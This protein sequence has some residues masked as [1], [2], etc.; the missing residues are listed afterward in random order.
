MGGEMINQI[1]LSWRFKEVYREGQYRIMEDPV[2][3]RFYI[4]RDFCFFLKLYFTA[5]F[6][7]LAEATD[8]LIEMIN[9]D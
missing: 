7:S 3:G 2:T 5:Y 9:N 6:F 4:N 8:T 1:L